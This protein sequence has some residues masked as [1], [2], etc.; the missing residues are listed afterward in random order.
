M[1]VLEEASNMRVLSRKFN[2]MLVRVSNGLESTSAAKIAFAEDLP[3]SVTDAVSADSIS[4]RVLEA[5]QERGRF[6]AL[7]T[8]GLEEILTETNKINL[9]EEVNKYKQLSTY[10]KMT[11]TTQRQKKKSKKSTAPGLGQ[12]ARLRDSRLDDLYMLTQIQTANLLTHLEK[13]RNASGDSSK[14]E[15]EPNKKEKALQALSESDQMLKKIR[16]FLK[17]YRKEFG[18]ASSGNSDSSIEDNCSPSP[19]PSMVRRSDAMT[20]ES[21]GKSIE[22]S[23]VSP[24]SSPQPIRKKPIPKPRRRMSDSPVQSP[25]PAKKMAAVLQELAAIRGPCPA[26]THSPLEHAVTVPLR[27]P[28]EET[29]DTGTL[30]SGIGDI[31]EWRRNRPDENKLSVPFTSQI[32]AVGKD[33]VPEAE[34]VYEPIMAQ[35]VTVPHYT[36][37]EY[38]QKDLPPRGEKK[39]L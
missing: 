18:L 7:N 2:Y 34:H 31:D 22:E 28:I 17:E 35:E 16:T 26:H 3:K 20:L 1:Q 15:D 11:K 25:A 37:L 4:L 30:D 32:V 8:E 19:S 23:G 9:L 13:L 39:T 38:P 33:E 5:L 12:D 27:P 36:Q 6:N 21:V 14:H 24:A 10:K 29:E